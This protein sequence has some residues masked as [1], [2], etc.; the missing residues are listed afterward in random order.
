RHAVARDFLRNC[1][2][3]RGL[4]YTQQGEHRLALREY[5]TALKFDD[6]GLRR[7]ILSRQRARALAYLKEHARATAAADVV[8]AEK[9]ADAATFYDAACVFALSAAVVDDREQAGMYATRSIVL[10][11]RAVEK[12]FRSAGSLKHEPDLASVRSRAD[13]RQLVVNLEA[14][15]ETES[16]RRA[17]ADGPNDV[18]PHLGLGDTFSNVN[19]H[20]DAEKAY[21]QAIM[22]RRD[23]AEA[24]YGLGLALLD[25]G[26]P[27]EAVEAFRKAIELKQNY[28]NAHYNLGNA[29]REMG[30][31]PD[32]AEAYRAAI[33]VAPG[34]AEAHCN[35]GHVL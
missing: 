14:L 16:Y 4:L 13:F 11:A 21:R 5:E 3:V 27:A 25:Q 15:Q 1:H 35:L 18:T 10:L 28:A 26:R 6:H 33:K 31:L 8:V 17:I 32:S 34:F 22:V 24:H 29:L 23:C 19:R 20:A 9:D 12:G 30:K 2:R 7:N